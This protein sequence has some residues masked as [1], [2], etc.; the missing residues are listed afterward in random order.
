MDGS[1]SPTALHGPL[2]LKF[3]PLVKPI[4]IADCLQSEFTP[5]ALCEENNEGR[6]ELGVQNLLEAVDN[7]PP[8]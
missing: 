6:V 2:V 4:A 5:H 3:H 7:N 1:R 8:L